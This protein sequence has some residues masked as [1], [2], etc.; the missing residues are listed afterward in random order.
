MKVRIKCAVP[1]HVR[2]AAQ[3]VQGLR[4]LDAKVVFAF[5]GKQAPGD[6]TIKLMALG[7]EES[8][9]VEVEL[10]GPDAE[11]ALAVIQDVLEAK[12]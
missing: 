4:P 2:P 3:L 9:E 10:S 12:G 8:A 11:A 1:L 5:D 7:A 6:S